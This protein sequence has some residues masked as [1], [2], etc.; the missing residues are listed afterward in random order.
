MRER[1]L[2]GR[3]GQAQERGPVEDRLPESDVEVLRG[4]VGVELARQRDRHEIGDTV[5]VRIVIDAVAVDVD[6]GAR[7]LAC[8]ALRAS[9]GV[10]VAARNQRQQGRARLR[11]R[12][13]RRVALMRRG[14][15]LRIVVRRQAIDVD[16]LVGRSR[17]SRQHEHRKQR[18][19]SRFECRQAHRENP[20]VKLSVD[21]V[22]TDQTA[23]VP[24]HPRIDSLG[25]GID[26]TFQMRHL[27]ETVVLQEAAC[28]FAANAV[29]A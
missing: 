15:D 27:G 20:P 18:G 21:A 5:A 24:R 19:S 2:V 28:M 9:L 4:V 22:V 11:P 6:G 25:P 14:C 26:S 1:E 17:R 7:T 12:F 8:R 29:V 10:T 23:S 16:E 13:E 3:F